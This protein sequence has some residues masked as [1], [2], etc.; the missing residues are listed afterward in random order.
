MLIFILIEQDDDIDVLPGSC[1]RLHFKLVFIE[2]F[3]QNSHFVLDEL[4]CPFIWQEYR[5]PNQTELI[6]HLSET[7]TPL[8]NK[9][10]LKFVKW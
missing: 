4:N 6:N 2:L 1:Q 3:T 10:N 8:W 9:Y 5:I 7:P